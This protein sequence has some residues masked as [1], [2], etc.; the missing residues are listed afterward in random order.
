[1]NPAGVSTARIVQFEINREKGKMPDSGLWGVSIID[2]QTSEMAVGFSY[3]KMG[4]DDLTLSDR[5]ELFALALSENYSRDFHVGFT[6]KYMKQREYKKD[7]DNGDLGIL[8]RISPDVRLAL[9]G[10]NLFSSKFDEVHKLYTGG[11]SYKNPNGFTLAFDIT[12][13][14]DTET[15]KDV[16]YS[17]GV[18]LGSLKVITLRGGYQVNKILDKKFYSFGG[19]YNYDGILLGYA[20][21]RDEVDSKN[22]TH[23]FS[24]SFLL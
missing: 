9:V 5:E 11:I 10:K 4:R 2:A 13:D 21:M 19:S 1:M 6:Y 20:V 17:Y 7:D 3:Y 16:T 14:K 12:K 18:E 24:V 8:Y 23:H 15:E 22:A